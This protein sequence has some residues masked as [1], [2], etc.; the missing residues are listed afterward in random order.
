MSVLAELPERGEQTLLSRIAYENLMRLMVLRHC[1]LNG[2][3]GRQLAILQ[4]QASGYTAMPKRWAQ[5]VNETR[6]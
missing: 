4:Q 6:E 2:Y 1:R 5:I 3:N